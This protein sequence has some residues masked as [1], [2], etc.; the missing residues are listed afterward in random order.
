[1]IAVGEVGLDFFRDHSPR[2]TQKEVL[3]Q[4]F[5]L[6]K[7]VQKPL[8]IH[9]RDAYDAKD[10]RL[11]TATGRFRFKAFLRAVVKTGTNV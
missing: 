4:F 7:E 9:C 11:E 10:F 6:S 2:D 1:M 5:H 8:V 3:R